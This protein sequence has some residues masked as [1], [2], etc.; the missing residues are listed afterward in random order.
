MNHRIRI[1]EVRLVDANGEQMG[2]VKTPDAIQRAENIGMDLVEI[3]PTARPPVCKIMDFGK[4]KYEQSKKKHEQK[5]KQTVIQVKE[6][7]V[8]PSTDEHDLNTKIRHIRR[9]LEAGNKVKVSIRFRGR[10]MAHTDLGKEQMSRLALEVKELGEVEY[11]P[12]MEG[13]QMFMVLSPIRKR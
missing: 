3:A 6:I 13:R 7:K 5:K 10:E 8:R 11:N 12:K 2:V 1:P 9:F 4:F